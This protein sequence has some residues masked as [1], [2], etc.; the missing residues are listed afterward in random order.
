MFE[1]RRVDLLLDG[2]KNK[3]FIGLKYNIMCHPTLLNDFNATATHL[4]DMV[5]RSPPGRQVSD[6][7]RSG[8]CGR[9]TGR[10]GR[11]GH[12][13]CDGR[14][15]RVFDSGRGHGG[16]END[17]GRRGDRIPSSTTLRPENCPYQDDVDRVQPIIVHRYVI[18]DRIFVDDDA[19]NKEMKAT[20]SH[21]VFQIRADLK[22]HKSP[23]GGITRKRTSEVAALQ[24]SL[25]ELSARVGNYPDNGT[26]DDRGRGQYPDETYSRSNKNQSGLVCQAYYE[27]KQKGLGD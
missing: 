12:S 20:E 17:R 22:A 14:G 8:G 11:D 4:K 5:N 19:Y 7:G 24:R 18:G 25:Q 9:G 6:M 27:K 3:A 15:G 16:R 13:G 21:T 26:E 1:N 2:I 23:L 10:G